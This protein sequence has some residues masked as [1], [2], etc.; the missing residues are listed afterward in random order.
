MNE[1]QIGKAL[2]NLES[3]S[4]GATRAPSEIA[5]RIIKRDRLRLRLLAGFSTFFWVVTV[6]GVIWLIV[7]YFL[8]V[9]P[10][11]DAYAAGRLQLDND[12]KDWIRAFD[13][14]AEILLTSIIAFLLAALGTVMLVLTSRR[15]TLRQINADLANISEQLRKLQLEEPK[16]L[17]ES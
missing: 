13:A 4:L 9:V 3:S 17:S 16:Q 14:G 7:F 6:A 10:R 5:Q 1:K 12:W 2:L 11:L 8:F 15:A